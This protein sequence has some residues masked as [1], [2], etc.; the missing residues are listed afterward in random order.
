MCGGEEPEM[1][2]EI[3]LIALSALIFYAFDRYAVGLE[4]L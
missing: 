4:S 1:L 3:G 2:L